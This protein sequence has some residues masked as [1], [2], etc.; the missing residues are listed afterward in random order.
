MLVPILNMASFLP[1]LPKI[2]LTYSELLTPHNVYLETQK[3]E[4]T[5]TKLLKLNLLTKNFII[6]PNTSKE[7][8]VKSMFPAEA[9]SIESILI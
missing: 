7:A 1:R 4:I 9:K 5:Q 2:L 3:R 6:G 8:S